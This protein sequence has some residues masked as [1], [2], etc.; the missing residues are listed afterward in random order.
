[1]WKVLSGACGLVLAS[2]LSVAAAQSIKI[3]AAENFYGD[4]AAAIGGD[5]VAVDNILTNPDTDPHDFEPTPSTARAVATGQIVIM[6]GADYDPWMARL[7]ASSKAKDRTVIDVATLIGRKAGDNPHIW[8]DVDAMKA[9]ADSLAKA[10]AAK[11]PAGAATYQTDLAAY[12]ETLQPIRDKIAAIRGRFA[13][14]PVT[15]TEPVFGYMADALGLTMRNQKF[16]IAVMNDA[17]PSAGDTA[18]FEDDIKGQKIKVLFYNSQVTDP[19]TEHL[20]DLAHKANVA[21][22]GV[23][24]TKPAGKTYAEWMLDTLDATAKALSG[25]ST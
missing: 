2:T 10:L 25:P 8:Y 22:V 13:G 9:L 18:A 17:E 11:D 3:V 24:E 19:Q 7:V 15:A 1:M 21:V 6:N 20:L 12:E 4:V 16:Q 14:A 23:T 5:R